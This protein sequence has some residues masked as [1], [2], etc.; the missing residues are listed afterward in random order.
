MASIIEPIY[1]SRQKKI[2]PVADEFS[3]FRRTMC[4]IRRRET[5]TDLTLG[6]LKWLWDE[7]EGICPLTDWIL[8]LPKST[9]KVID[10]P[11]GQPSR[12]DLG[13]I[14]RI[15]NELGYCRGNV[16]WIA[17]MANVARGG[18]SDKQFVEMCNAVSRRHG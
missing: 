3:K 13:T 6:Y 9:K 16:R 4:S 14:D 10:L 5:H 11:Q 17:Y 15:D 8:W 18:F 12:P 2:G 7:Q 1:D